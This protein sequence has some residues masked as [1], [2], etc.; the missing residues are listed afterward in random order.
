MYLEIIKGWSRACNKE[1]SSQSV[2]Y[3]FSVIKKLVHR[4]LG[5]RLYCL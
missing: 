5:T 4:D 3:R 2:T 1:N